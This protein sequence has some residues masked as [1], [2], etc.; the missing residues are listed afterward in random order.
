[1]WANT[2]WAYTVGGDVNVMYQCSYGHYDD[3][4]DDDD[5]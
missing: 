5:T 4:D 2:K 1:M 3:D